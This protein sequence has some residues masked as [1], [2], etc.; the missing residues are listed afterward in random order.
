[1]KAEKLQLIPRKYKGSLRDYYTQLCA[2][3]LDNLED[4]DKFLDTYN[5]PRWIMKEQKILNSPIM[6]KEI[7]A[8]KKGTNKQMKTQTSQ[9]GENQDQMVSLVNSTKCLKN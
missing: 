4:M 3:K 8:G 9:K 7:E 1:M 5:L 6:S 2:N